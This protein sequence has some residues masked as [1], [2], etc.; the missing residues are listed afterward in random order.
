LR[1]TCERLDGRHRC[2]AFDSGR[3]E[4]DRWLHASALGSDG[5]NIT[6]TYVWHAGDD[7]VVGYYALMPFTL[8]RDRLSRKQARGLPDRI[9]GYLIAR[10]AL[11]AGLHGAG[12]GTQLLSS[13]LARVAVGGQTLGGRFV[14]VDAIDEAA[15]SFYV[16]HGF[17]PVPDI[18][19]RLV[20]ATKGL[21]RV[22]PS[23]RPPDGP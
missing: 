22:V 18:S 1:F 20:L 8:D 7:V 15:A 16:H 5:R 17:E 11:D 3:P 12:L 23:S 9:P 4:L 2:D 13:A 10:L 19:G 6:R 21:E 14:V